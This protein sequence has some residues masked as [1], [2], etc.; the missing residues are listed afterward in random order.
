MKKRESKPSDQDEAEKAFNLI[1]K[2]V[3]EN[4]QIES[5]IWVAGCW[6]ALVNCYQDSGMSFECF[7]QEMEDVK[8]CYRVWWEKYD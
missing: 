8:K 7:C 6:S 1:K 2:L 5:S 3:I 4:P